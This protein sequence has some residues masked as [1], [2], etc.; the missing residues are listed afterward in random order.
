MSP[1]KT[2]FHF[3]APAGAA[4]QPLATLPPY[5]CGVP[6]AGKRCEAF[7]HGGLSNSLR[8]PGGIS[9]RGAA[10]LGERP[11]PPL[12][13]WRSPPWP[14]KNPEQLMRVLR[15]P[16]KVKLSRCAC[17]R[18]PAS[19]RLRAQTASLRTGLVCARPS[20]P[21]G[22]LATAPRF[23]YA[24]AAVMMAMEQ[25]PRARPAG[26]P[27]DFIRSGQMN[28][29]GGKVLRRWRKTLE[30]RTAPPPPLAGW[31]SPPWP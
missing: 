17:S 16:A 4:A 10:V 20:S 3:F 8:A 22:L 6:L 5:G 19:L 23:S 2:D 1:E 7:P 21:S 9:A 15:V 18:R 12:A 27:N 26:A 24:K 11:P 25:S 13:G 29:P 30:R 28:C 14:K 31:R